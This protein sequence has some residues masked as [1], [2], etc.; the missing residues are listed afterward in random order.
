M[1]G[2]HA[3]EGGE[4]AEE[5]EEEHRRQVHPAGFGV[6]GKGGAAE[7]VRIPA[8]DGEVSQALAEERVPG[9]EEGEDV[10]AGQPGIEGEAV[11]CHEDGETGEDG[12]RQN[13]TS[14]GWRRL[15]GMW[16]GS[17][18]T[19]RSGDAHALMASTTL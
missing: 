10:E 15:R 9:Q 7:E 5:R 13:I 2:D 3:L 11:P 16:L 8:R 19:G 17:A 12:Q 1:K 6:A 4:G 18:G 14:P